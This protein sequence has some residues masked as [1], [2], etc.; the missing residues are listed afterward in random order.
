MAYYLGDLSKLTE[1]L[2]AT[3]QKTGLSITYLDF[4][5]GPLEA[6]NTFG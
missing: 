4:R 3:E 1:V 5:K 6:N 2:V